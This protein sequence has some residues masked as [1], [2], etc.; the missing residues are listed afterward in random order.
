MRPYVITIRGNSMRVLS[1]K[2]AKTRNEV[3]FVILEGGA[4][5][6][7]VGEGAKSLA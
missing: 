2:L 7:G 3:E 1:N 6:E 4:A 5:D